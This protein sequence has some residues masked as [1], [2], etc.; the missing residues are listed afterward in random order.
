MVSGLESGLKKEM[1]LRAAKGGAGR[2]SGRKRRRR[3]PTE[4][5]PGQTPAVVEHDARREGLAI[6]KHFNLLA[7]R[8]SRREMRLPSPSLRGAKRRSNPFFVKQLRDGLLR[9]KCS[10]Q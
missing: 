1:Q 10:S 5:A 2:A 7:Q 6:Q 3:Q 4:E 9:R 8:V